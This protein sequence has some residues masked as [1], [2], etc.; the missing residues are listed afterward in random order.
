MQKE[1]KIKIEHEKRKKELKKSVLPSNVTSAKPSRFFTSV[2]S[3]TKIDNFL[4]N[5]NHK[6]L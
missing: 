3:S 2:L 4:A 6:T 1:T 5:K